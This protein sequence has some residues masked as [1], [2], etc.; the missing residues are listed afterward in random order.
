MLAMHQSYIVANPGKPLTTARLQ[1]TT[2]MIIEYRDKNINFE[3][4]FL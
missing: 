4:Q 3:Q 1:G 2:E